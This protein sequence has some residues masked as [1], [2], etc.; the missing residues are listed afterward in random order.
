MMGQHVGKMNRN[1]G[2]LKFQGNVYHANWMSQ[3]AGEEVIARFHPE[4]LF[5]GVEIYTKQ[6][7]Y[8]GFAECQQKTGFYDLVGAR[9]HSKRQ[10]KIR[11]AE[12]ALA[13]AHKP[14]PIQEI[15]AKL[16]A[17][18]PTLPAHV[19]AKVVA[20]PQVARRPAAPDPAIN[21]A[22]VEAGRA[23]IVSMQQRRKAETAVTETAADRFWWAQDMLAKSAAGKPIGTEEARKLSAY[24]AT[25]EYQTNLHMFENH[26]AEAVR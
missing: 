20:L 8:L 5:A 16:D 19:E 6:N 4:D 7:E 23:E 17:L 11:R 3:R 21:D 10:A 12:K 1:N 18:S 26:G 25:A 22:A 15:A 2:S 13:D 14:V 24:I 9:L